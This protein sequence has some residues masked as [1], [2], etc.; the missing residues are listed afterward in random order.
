MVN[1]FVVEHG[2]AL[3]STFLKELAIENRLII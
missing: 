2:L 1:L 3:L